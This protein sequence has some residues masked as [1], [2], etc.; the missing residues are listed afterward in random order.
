[1]SV[2]NLNDVF[3]DFYRFSA[4]DS[5][6]LVGPFSVLRSVV[7]GHSPTN[8]TAAVFSSANDSSCISQFT[9][10]ASKTCPL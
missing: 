4:Y 10:A 7:L 2:V 9:R 3:A 8:D 5:F 6:A 1:M